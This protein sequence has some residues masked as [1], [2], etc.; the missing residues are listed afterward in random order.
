MPAY[1]RYIEGDYYQNFELIESLTPKKRAILNALRQGYPNALSAKDLK[2][3]HGIPENTAHQYLDPLAKA[4][5]IGKRRERDKKT[6][7]DNQILFRG[8]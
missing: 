4:Q 2:R 6:H 5:I 8:L 1:D 3:Q 7:R